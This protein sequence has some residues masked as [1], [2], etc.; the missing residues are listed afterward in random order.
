MCT[1]HANSAREAVTNVYPASARRG[2]RGQ[3]IV[4]PTV[5]GSI[6]L[7]VQIALE[8]DGVRRAR[9]IVAVPGRLEGDV[10]EMRTSSPPAAVGWCEQRASRL[11]WTASSARP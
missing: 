2:E 1:L 10:I 8:R 6:D 4:V 7:V 11:T 5:A 9:E 3:S